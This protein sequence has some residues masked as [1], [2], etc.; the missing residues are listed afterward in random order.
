MELIFLY[1]MKQ[2]MLL[3]LSRLDFPGIVL[4]NK[5][6]RTVVLLNGEIKHLCTIYMHTGTIHGYQYNFRKIM[7][8]IIH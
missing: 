5:K 4:I 6:L 1:H 2:S 7:K 8:K 3:L